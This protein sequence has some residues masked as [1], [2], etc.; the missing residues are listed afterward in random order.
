[1]Q[2]LPFPCL[3]RNLPCRLC[4]G[5]FWTYRTS[6]A[7]RPPEWRPGKTPR[8]GRRGSRPTSGTARWPAFRLSGS[9]RCKWEGP[10]WR[11]GSSWPRR[12][13][14]VEPGTSTWACISSIFPGW[15]LTFP[16]RPSWICINWRYL[17]DFWKIYWKLNDI[18]LICISYYVNPLEQLKTLEELKTN[19]N[20][21]LILLHDQ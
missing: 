12:R 16:S 6:P 15:P 13:K 8:S 19:A 3:C 4:G 5:K 14:S 7:T 20:N 10:W 11:T 21:Y 18:I 2:K 17:C 9:T 1:M